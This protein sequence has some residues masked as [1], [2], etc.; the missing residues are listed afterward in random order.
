[1]GD[2]IVSVNGKNARDFS[3]YD[4]REQFKRDVGTEIALKVKGKQ[5]ERS[6]ILTLADQ[7]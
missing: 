5:G 4:L 7:V 3:L 6:V 1:V 2:E